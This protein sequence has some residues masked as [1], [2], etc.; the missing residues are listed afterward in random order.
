[1][2]MIDTLEQYAPLLAKNAIG[3]G[4]GVLAGLMLAGVDAKLLD[5]KDFVKSSNIEKIGWSTLVTWAG[6][7]LEKIA[8]GGNSSR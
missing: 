2:D 1:M 8:T 3:Y 6:D 5:G 4:S 7:G